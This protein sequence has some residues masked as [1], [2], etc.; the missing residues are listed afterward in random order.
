QRVE[1][2]APCAGVT[3]WLPWSVASM[4]GNLLPPSDSGA[5]QPYVEGGAP[6]ASAPPP[7]PPMEPEG[8]MQLG[9][10]I[11]AIKRYRWLILAVVVAGTGIGLLA[12]RFI[13]PVYTVN[14]TIYIRAP[15]GGDGR[16]I[17]ESK[18]LI[19]GQNWVQLLTT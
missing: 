12:T 13:D 7:L 2:I 16:N 4:A 17:G 19:E 18:G 6:V 14:S 15:E 8:G 3:R 5:V 1:I 9:R 10:Y 11:S